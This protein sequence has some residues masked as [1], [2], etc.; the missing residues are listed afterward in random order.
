MT[1]FPPFLSPCPCLFPCVAVRTSWR[2][3]SR[4][5]TARP[6]ARDDAPHG[7]PH[8]SATRDISADIGHLVQ[9]R[10]VQARGS[11]ISL[12]TIPNEETEQDV[13]LVGCDVWLIR[14]R[15]E[16][17]R[18]WSTPRS[19][20]RDDKTACPSCTSLIRRRVWRRVCV[21]KTRVETRV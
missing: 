7:P 1:H 11:I 2:T 18:P 16:G 8:R 13:W 3:C 15:Q 14:R 6:T 17:H 4:S 5:T 9:A 12:A 10:L 20:D 21:E 19:H